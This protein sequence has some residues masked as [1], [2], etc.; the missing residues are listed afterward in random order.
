MATPER[1]WAQLKFCALGLGEPFIANLCG[2]WLR[3]YTPDQQKL[4]ERFGWHEVE[5]SMVDGEL[6]SIMA[7]NAARNTSV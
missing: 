3:L 6:V 5:Q 7:R 4:Y 1:A 2:N